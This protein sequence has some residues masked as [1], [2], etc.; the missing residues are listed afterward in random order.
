MSN[1]D[2]VTTQPKEIQNH[3]NNCLSQNSKEY[4]AEDPSLS[5]AFHTVSETT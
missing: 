5:L 4:I 3:T 1:E 2:N